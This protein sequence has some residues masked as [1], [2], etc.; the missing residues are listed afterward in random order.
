VRVSRHEFDPSDKDKICGS[1]I[2]KALDLLD[3]M[4]RAHVP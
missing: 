3:D 1:A 4:L 2:E